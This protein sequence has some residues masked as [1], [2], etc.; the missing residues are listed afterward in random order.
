MLLL[1]KGKYAN[2]VAELKQAIKLQ[3][4]SSN[5][6]L[7]NIL[8]QG[9]QGVAQDCNQAF[10]FA[11]QGACSH[12]YQC[13]GMMAFCYWGGLGCAIDEPK[14]IA[15]ARNSAANGSKYGQHTLGKLYEEGTGGILKDYAA[16][17]AQY[18]LAAAQGHERAQNE[19]GRMYDKGYGVL[20]DHAEALRWYK[21]AA[22]Q[23][24][25]VALNNI[26][27]HYEDGLSV[28]ADKTEAIRWY[29]RA[30]AAKFHEAENNLIRL[31]AARD[32]ALDNPVIGRENSRY[33]M[34][35]GDDEFMH[36]CWMM[37][38]VYQNSS[39]QSAA[40][41]KYFK[42][43]QDSMPNEPFTQSFLMNHPFR[44]EFSSVIFKNFMMFFITPIE[45]TSDL[46]VC[47]QCYSI[48]RSG[49]QMN[50]SVQSCT[51][52]KT[53]YDGHDLTETT[54][55]ESDSRVQNSDAL[56]ELKFT[57]RQFSIVCR[58]LR[59]PEF[60]EHP[61][62]SGNVMKRFQDEIFKR[63]K[64]RND[65]SIVKGR[66]LS[67]YESKKD[68]NLNKNRL[69][70]ENIND[71]VERVSKF[72]KK[73]GTVFQFCKA[74]K[75]TSSFRKS[76]SL[77]RFI[78]F[79]KA[80]IDI[81]QNLVVFNCETMCE[82][83]NAFGKALPDAFFFDKNNPFKAI[84]FQYEAESH[85]EDFDS[86]QIE[87]RKKRRSINSGHHDEW[88]ELFIN[89][90][91]NQNVFKN[92]PPCKSCCVDV[93]DFNLKCEWLEETHS[94][95]P[96]FKF[97]AAPAANPMV[98]QTTAA[99]VAAVAVVAAE[100]L[101]AAVKP[102]RKRVC[103]EKYDAGNVLIIDDAPNDAAA[104][105][106]RV[107]MKKSSLVISTFHPTV[108]TTSTFA[109][110]LFALKR[111]NEVCVGRELFHINYGV[112]S[113][114]FCDQHV[115]NVHVKRSY[116]DG[117]DAIVEFG[118]PWE[119]ITLQFPNDT[120]LWCV[121]RVGHEIS[122]LFDENDKKVTFCHKNGE[123]DF[124]NVGDTFGQW[125]KEAVAACSLA[126]D[127]SIKHRSLQGPVDQP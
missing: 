26:G 63:M 65:V 6:D 119:V 111:Y 104:A 3:H 47:D 1:A 100:P 107:G 2:A 11:E 39:M 89:N 32:L 18:R 69:F 74:F 75:E 34:T 60:L 9:R 121:G 105:A 17:V 91:D 24:L 46:Q 12:C 94:S 90:D 30:V 27:M 37:P 79:L 64:A 42:S 44:R 123:F 55:T 49:M 80:L 7:A 51:I 52:T 19:L 101:P 8:I 108:T 110:P 50:Y 120:A 5:A 62:D 13:E 48:W 109:M 95:L 113:M 115:P 93:V 126:I 117:M 56:I 125:A 118:R 72:E 127:S 61:P 73:K 14:S 77:L 114:K 67:F 85:E 99:A 25:G 84:K 35:L 103:F 98:Q 58:V 31:E 4:V 57:T 29:Q 106:E 82:A 88:L 122:V 71:H 59:D 10:K 36:N 53:S 22:A 87:T 68:M 15:L 83:M 33:A 102:Q 40:A 66:F 43:F 20:Q 96:C 28:A 16:A 23:G 97:S 54:W 76:M 45:R 21:L 81:C 41:I 92:H 112:V 116:E 38:R 124:E 70:S 78:A 86:Q